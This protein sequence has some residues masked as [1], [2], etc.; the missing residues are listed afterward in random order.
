MREIRLVRSQSTAD[1]FVFELVPENRDAELSLHSMPDVASEPERFVVPVTK[2][3]RDLI[4]PPVI[5]SRSPQPHSDLALTAREIQDRIRS[6]QSPEEVAEAARVSVDRISAFALPVIRERARVVEL[7]REAVVNP[8]ETNANL[9]VSC[10]E[11]FHR[12]TEK[13]GINFDS[14]SWDSTRDS[15]RHWFVTVTWTD[16]ANTVTDIAA[17]EAKGDSE[18]YTARWA[19][20]FRRAGSD[21][22]EPSND[23]A[24]EVLS[25]IKPE[26]KAPAPVSELP[27]PEPEDSAEDEFAL[28][29]PVEEPEHKSRRRKSTKPNWEDVV[30]GLQRSTKR[31]RNG[32]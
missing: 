17:H 7:A 13:K 21:Y 16:A 6:G 24:R 12:Y 8:D 5:P 15:H 29:G 3:M 23:L 2:E 32:E 19:F 20:T 25:I 22:L 1:K 14:L 26:E 30:L 10:E 28:Q 11:L 27:Q 31:P 9:S 4:I 18:T